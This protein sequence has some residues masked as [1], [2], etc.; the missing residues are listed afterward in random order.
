MDNL[1]GARPHLYIL[2]DHIPVAVYD[3]LEWGMWYES[4]DEK[5]IVKQEIVEGGAKISTVFLGI[6]H[7]FSWLPSGTG[8]PLLFETMVFLGE[9]ILDEYTQRYATWVGPN[10]AIGKRWCYI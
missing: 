5:R 1:P 7:G 6:D 3:A 2:N 8:K 9:E 10:T 4:A